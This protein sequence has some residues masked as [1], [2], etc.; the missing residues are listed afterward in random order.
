MLAVSMLMCIQLKA[1]FTITPVQPPSTF[2]F[3]DLWHLNIGGPATSN[4]IEFQVSVRIY[5]NPTSNLMVK[6]NSAIFPFSQI[7]LYANHLNLGPLAPLSTLYYDYN[8]QN[9]IQNGGFF[10][11]GV[12][13]IQFILL[14]RPADGEFTELAE[15]DYQMVVEAFWPPMLLDPYNQDTIDNPFPILIWTPAFY[16]SPGTTLEYSLWLVKLNANQ[17][18]YQGIASNPYILQNHNMMG[19]TLPYP[20]SAYNMQVGD[21]F[22]WQVAATV[23]N[24]PVAYTEVWTFVYYVDTILDTTHVTEK[25]FFNLKR[26]EERT[27]TIEALYVVQDKIRF[28]FDQE[29]SSPDTTK[30]HFTIRDKNDHVIF[31]SLQS[32]LFPLG[33]GMNRFELDPC[34]LNLDPEASF[35]KLIAYNRKKEPFYMFFKLSDEFNCE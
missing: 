16:A 29:Y 34:L 12:Y 5:D 31:N 18:P 20:P 26:V 15:F 23:N 4:Y 33:Y 27:Q 19:T 6:S 13:D 21:Q 25:L 32:N 22:A 35:Y 24:Q 14:G 7:P 2:T 30:I 3:D 11:V 9:I 8:L 28:Q 1:Q 10:P 17:D